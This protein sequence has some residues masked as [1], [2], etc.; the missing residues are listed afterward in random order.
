MLARLSDAG[1]RH[2]FGVPSDYG[3]RFYEEIT[4]S[5]IKH[6][7]TRR[8]DTAAFAGDGYARC[9]G[10]GGLAVTYGV[11]ALSALSAVAGAIAE[12]SPVVVTSGA[13][14]VRER[15]E[16]PLLHHRFGPFTFQRE[17]LERII[18]VTAVLDDPVMAF[19]LIDRA[20]AAHAH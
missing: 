19:C 2:I 11:G 5:P 20:T 8:E 17:I 10:L 16:D 15:R 12:S 1:A 13:P 7:G 14:G 9:L 18:C 3:L 4:R 6:I